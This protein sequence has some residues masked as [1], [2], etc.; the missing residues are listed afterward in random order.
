MNSIGTGKVTPR[1]GDRQELVDLPPYWG[2]PPMGHFPHLGESPLGKISHGGFSPRWELA[3]MGVFPQEAFPNKLKNSHL[4]EIPN[5][6]LF[7]HVS[8]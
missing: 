6:V 3:T 5:N 2:M 1:F 7:C 4:G 8:S